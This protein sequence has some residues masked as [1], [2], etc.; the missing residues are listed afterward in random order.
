MHPTL[1]QRAAEMRPPSSLTVDV[2]D[3]MPVVVSDFLPRSSVDDIASE[4]TRVLIV[5]TETTGL[6]LDL[7]EP[8]EVGLLPLYVDETGRPVGLWADPIGQLG[9]PRRP[10][11]RE[12]QELCRIRWEDVEGHSFDLDVIADLFNQADVVVAHNATFDRAMIGRLDIHHSLWAC[13]RS[14]IP[15]KDGIAKLEILA[16]IHGFIYQAHRALGDCWATACLLNRAGAWLD[17]LEECRRP[18]QRI[19]ARAGLHERMR[20][21]NA[22]WLW[23]ADDKLWWCDDSIEPRELALQRVRA[24]GG[25]AL[26][27]VVDPEDRTDHRF[28][29]NWQR[30]G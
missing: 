11:P 13:S 6:D 3:P 29:P 17:L 26:A 20:F 12:V 27:C 19:A 14:M 21:K 9:Q 24:A 22:G 16:L 30:V 8:W 5:D 25:K 18:S 2:V 7:D 15:W 4:C 28:R 1:F 10:I 23:D